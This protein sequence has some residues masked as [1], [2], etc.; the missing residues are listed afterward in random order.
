MKT[1]QSIEDICADMNTGTYFERPDGLVGVRILWKLHWYMWRKDLGG[2]I[3]TESSGTSGR[4]ISKRLSTLPRSLNIFGLQS[5]HHPMF[6]AMAQILSVI[7]SMLGIA[8]VLYRHA[9]GGHG[10]SGAGLSLLVALMASALIPGLLFVA[11]WYYLS[12]WAGT[13]LKHHVSIIILLPCLSFWCT[14]TLLQW[15]AT[16]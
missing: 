3:Y 12:H 10:F 7:S 9:L 6:T 15:F 8:L 14:V 2:Y 11:P 4:S 1:Y 5:I 16:R 13:K